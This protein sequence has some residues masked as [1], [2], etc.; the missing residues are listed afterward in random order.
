MILNFLY[1]SHFSAADFSSNI[2]HVEN[3]VSNIYNWMSSNFISFISSKTEFLILVP[4]QQLVKLV[5]STFHLPNNVSLAPIDSAL[6]LG[7]IF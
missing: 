6:D 7:V 1:H 2:T 3:T 4:A 5:S